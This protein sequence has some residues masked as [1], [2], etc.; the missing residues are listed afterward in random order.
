FVIGFGIGDSAD[1]S[2]PPVEYAG[3]NACV[4]SGVAGEGGGGLVSDSD[5]L[6]IGGGV[7]GLTLALLA[8]ERGL[9]TI[10]VERGAVGAGA[11]SGS[12]GILHGGL[13]HLSRLR[14]G[15]MRRSARG[16]AWFRAR[17]PDHVRPIPCLLPLDG[18][19]LRRRTPFEFALALEERLRG[20]KLPA[21][22]RVLRPHEAASL[23]PAMRA[24]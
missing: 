22:G 4:A 12:F 10:L 19:G 5:L 7:H 8:A 14:L 9:R 13:R 3:E 18:R 24:E 1:R 15:G 21:Q 11:S 17:F 23:C 16:Q 6:I 20:E 2:P